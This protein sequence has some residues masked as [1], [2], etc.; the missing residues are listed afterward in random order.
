[1]PTVGITLLTT[2]PVLE[3]VG[4]IAETPLAGTAVTVPSCRTEASCIGAATAPL[5]TALTSAAPRSATAVIP[6]GTETAAAGTVMSITITAG[7]LTAI[8][9]T[10]VPLTAVTLTAG[11]GPGGSF[12][13]T[14]RFAPAP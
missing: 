3:A 10:A 14:G 6:I 5:E 12:T 7:A 8:P 2:V 11:A 4:T 13:T 9:L 1:M